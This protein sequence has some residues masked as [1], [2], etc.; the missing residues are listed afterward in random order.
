M[1][2]QRQEMNTTGVIGALKTA[3]IKLWIDT[4]HS[5]KVSASVAVENISRN[6]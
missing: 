2:G 1:K 4:K 3:M 5:W 6:D